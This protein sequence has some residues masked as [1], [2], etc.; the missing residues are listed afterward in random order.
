MTDCAAQSAGHNWWDVGADVTTALCYLGNIVITGMNYIL[1]AL[2]AI[3]DLMVPSDQIAV[4]VLNLWSFLQGKAPFGYVI[5]GLTA[6]GA[7]LGASPM[8]TTVT[9]HIAGHTWDM[10]FNQVAAG[11][12]SFRTPM[13]AAIWLAAVIGVVLAARE[14][15]TR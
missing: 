3:I 12:S 5:S 1:D 13:D 8:A 6:F 7:A 10:D 11:M 4:P 14:D 15:I 9:W 2:N